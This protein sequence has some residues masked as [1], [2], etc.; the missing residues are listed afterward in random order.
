VTSRG[1]CGC[2]VELCLAPKMKTSALCLVASANPH[3]AANVMGARNFIFG[4]V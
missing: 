4:I 2:S 1:N 3:R